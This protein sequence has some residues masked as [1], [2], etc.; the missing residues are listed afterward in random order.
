MHLTISGQMI[1]YSATM[2]FTTRAEIASDGFKQEDSTE[3]SELAHSRLALSATEH[4]NTSDVNWKSLVC[5]QK[6]SS[7]V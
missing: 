2:Q 6:T 7:P 5:L 3:Q 4:R 1:G